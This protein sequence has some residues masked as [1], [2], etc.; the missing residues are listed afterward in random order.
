[1][2]TLYISGL[3]A[4]SLVL[5]ACGSD[6]PAAPSAPA[7]PRGEVIGAP[8]SLPV[9]LKASIDAGTTSTGAIAL[10]GAA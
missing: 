7:Y 5:A 2:K 4:L 10:T 9:V 1:M 6:D 3:T 8:V